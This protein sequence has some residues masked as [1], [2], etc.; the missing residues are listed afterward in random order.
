[1]VKHTGV[2]EYLR[3]GEILYYKL[4]GSMLIDCAKYVSGG[5]PF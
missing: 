4:L 2:N 5:K 1:M 3:F